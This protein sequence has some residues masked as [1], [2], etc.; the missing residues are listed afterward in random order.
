MLAAENDCIS[1]AKV[2]GVADVIRDVPKALAEHNINVDVVIPDYGYY[3][4]D[5]NGECVAQV[6][7]SFAHQ[8]HT[9]YLYKLHAIS[10]EKVTQY[11]VVHPLFQQAG[12]SR[13]YCRTR[14]YHA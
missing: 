10:S 11:V 3:H 5:Y 8:Q 1:G 14:C 12:E 2:G 4:N 7:F 9:A 13:V 6:S